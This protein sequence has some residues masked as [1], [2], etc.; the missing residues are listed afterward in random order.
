MSQG[1]EWSLHACLNLA[2]AHG[3]AVTATRLAA[4][5]DLS[6]TSLNKQ[7]QLLAKAGIV[8]STSGPAGGFVLA[9]DPSAITVLDVVEAIEGSAGAFRC[10]E[11]RQRGPLPASGRTLRNPCAIAATMARAEDAWRDVLASTTIADLSATVE[12]QVRGV[13]VAVRSWLTAG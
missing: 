12:G 7:L 10:A 2:W 13:P 5:N 9:R 11:I 6:P 4:L 3:A 8:R 1:V